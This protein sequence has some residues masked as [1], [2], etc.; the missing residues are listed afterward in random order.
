MTCGTKKSKLDLIQ[1]ALEFLMIHSQFPGGFDR[2]LRHRDL[3]AGIRLDGFL[4]TR[5]EKSRFE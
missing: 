2:Q 5:D 4:S 3:N 1:M